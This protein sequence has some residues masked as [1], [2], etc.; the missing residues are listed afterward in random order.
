MGWVNVLLR[1]FLRERICNRSRG[2]ATELTPS[3]DDG[4]SYTVSMQVGDGTAQ[5]WAAGET[6]T[7]NFTQTTFQIEVA[8]TASGGNCATPLSFTGATL[9]TEVV[10]TGYV[11]ILCGLFGVLLP[12]RLTRT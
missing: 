1:L 10:P 3:W 5:G 6:Y 4:D 12:G 2:V 8:C 9:Q 11:A 7:Q